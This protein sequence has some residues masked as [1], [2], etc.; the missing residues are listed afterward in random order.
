M[1]TEH[2]VVIVG[3]GPVGL[4]LALLLS[5]QGIDVGV[6][7]KWHQPYGLPRAVGLSHDSMRVLQATGVLRDL[8]QHIDLHYKNTSGEYFTA[9]GEVLVRFDF[10]GVDQSGFPSM[11]PFD[12][13]GFEEAI[14]A[15]AD[16]NPHIT[17]HRG[18]AATAMRQTPDRAYVTFTPANGEQP[19]EGEPLEV[20]ARFVVGCDGGNSTIRRLIDAPMT[21]TGFT[22]VWMVVDIKPDAALE[23]SLPFGQ[24]L[25][26]RRPT[27]IVPAGPGR[28]R[29]EFIALP[30]ETPEELGKP[31]RVWALLAPWGVTPA[32][33]EL[34]RSSVYRFFARWATDWRNG[35]ILLCGD[36]AHQTPPF[37]G[38]GFNSGMR[39]AAALAWRLALV[40]KGQAS[41]KLLD[42][43][44]SERVPHVATVI[45]QAV[46]IGQMICITEEEQ[47]RARD[48][49]LR[50]LRDNPPEEPFLAPWLLGPGLG[51]VGDPAARQLAVQARVT[52]DGKTG[53]LDDI[54]GSSRFTI[55][56]RGGDPLSTMSDDALA[57]WQSLGGLVVRL[58]DELSD[59]D[60]AYTR[61]FDEL[62]ADLVLVRPDFYVFG[63]G[64]MD[65][66]GAMVSE[67]AEQ[68]GLTAA[69]NS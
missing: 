17:I 9:D 24:S 19:A 62:G 50:V 66:A 55:L 22:S 8:A 45:Q 26:H 32:N 37:L 5:R 1:A 34:V 4:V 64:A 25:D 6:F 33:A 30:G 18:W 11:M 41:P 56:S 31:E 48:A 67:L 16:A 23:E 58:G 53:L 29:F 21:D 68:I 35:R 63:A 7:E 38:Q 52:L 47:A 43:Y 14:L 60:G 59:T 12:Q 2:D 3:A 40:I 57:A 20:G 65:E 54:L 42:S 69:V 27:T 10:P 39:D 49:Q 15:A 61:W 51:R 13:P 28:R 46:G 44:T 36:A